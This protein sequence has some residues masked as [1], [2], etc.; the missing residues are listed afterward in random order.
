MLKYFFFDQ[1]SLDRFAAYCQ[2]HGISHQETSSEEGKEIS[3]PEEGIEEETLDE[4]EEEYDR[5][6]EDS[7]D[8]AAQEEQSPD[9]Y[10]GAGISVRLE[11][12]RRVYA[13]VQ[14]DILSRVMSVLSHDEL[15]QLVQSI[16]TAVQHPDE[17]SFCQRMRD[18]S[19]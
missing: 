18:L 12:G 3:L 9:N 13:D 11:D 5:C 19:E 6:L 17:R 1:A 8:R 4:I 16:V 15:D 2:R 7:F 14:M 10:S